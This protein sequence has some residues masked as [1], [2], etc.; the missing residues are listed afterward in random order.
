[1]DQNQENTLGRVHNVANFFKKHAG[2]VA[3]VGAL[4]LAVAA[5][6]LKL[7]KLPDPPEAAGDDDTSGTARTGAK[8]AKDDSRTDLVKPTVA[9]LSA[10]RLYYTAQYAQSQ[11]VEDLKRAA[12]M[13]LKRPGDIKR[14]MATPKLQRL[15]GRALDLLDPLPTDTLKA[16]YNHDDDKVKRFKKLAEQFGA[17]RD[18][19]RQARDEAKVEGETFDQDLKTARDYIKSDLT[20]AVDLL[21][22]END[23]FVRGFRQANKQ[24]DRRGG[25]SPRPPQPPTP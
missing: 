2:V 3:G 23:E 4:A 15:L 19:P 21:A 18:A 10:L 25:Q 5:Y 7:N 9:M 22:G 24:D 16:S 17:V 14:A 12:E 20:P 1:M 11:D 8:K 13:T 6:V